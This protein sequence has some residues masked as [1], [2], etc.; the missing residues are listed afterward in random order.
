MNVIS[1]PDLL[2]VNAT[3]VLPTL[4]KLRALRDDVVRPDLIV[5]HGG[6][7]HTWW[8]ILSRRRGHT[9]PLLRLRAHD[10]RPPA[11]HPFA[12][13]L[14]HYR[15]HGVVV[16]NERQRRAYVDRAGITPRRVH[17]VPP[18][19]PLS[20]WRGG[21]DRKEVREICGVAEDGLLIASIARFAPQKD[22]ETFFVAA[23]RVAE[24]EEGVHFLVAGYPAERSSESIRRLAA[25]YPVLEGRW[26]LWDER[27]ADGRKLVR[28]ADIGVIHS[29]RSEAICRVAMEYMAE[30]IPLVCS[31]IGALPEITREWYSA[32]LVPPSRA[33]DLAGAVVR[34][35]RSPNLRERLGWAGFERLTD[36][37]DR[38]DAI[39]RFERIMKRY[40]PESPAGGARPA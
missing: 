13:W 36:S 23:A 11:R 9:V 21:P 3:N 39:D 5:A 31:R 25:H 7:D 2:R 12:R 30:S 22:H 10:P 32:L 15:T 19:F 37:F 35:I 18:G 40:L 26:T 14:H 28:A 27:L 29:A 20:E 33:D 1:E 4:R 6:P 17:R 38:K 34:L 8:G 24:A 16:A